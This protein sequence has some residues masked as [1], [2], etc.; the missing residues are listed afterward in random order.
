MT[1]SRETAKN[2]SDEIIYEA[3][4]V[5]TYFPVRHGLL[6]RVTGHVR[7]VD[8]VSISVE[9]GETVGIVGESGC[10]K[11]TFGRTL[12]RLIE[13]TEGSLRFFYNGELRDFLS[14]TDEEL[15][16]S[17]REMQ[18][19]FQDPYS[20]LNPRMTVKDII[21]EPL[22]VQGLARK[23]DVQEKVLEMLE[24]VS[25]RR[26]HMERFPHAFSGGQ[27]Q[28][29]AIARAMV[30]GPR[31]LVAD[32]PVSALDVSVQAQI[33]NLLMD[34]QT[35]FNLTMLFIAHD[36][37][38]VRH[39]SDRIAVM[40]LGKIVEIGNA[41]TICTQP[42]HP[43]TEALL[44]SVPL[45]VPGG[46]EQKPTKAEKLPDPANPP[47]GCY[48]HER[49]RY[50]ADVCAAQPPELVSRDSEQGHLS[51]CHFAGELELKGLVIDTGA[52]AVIEKRKSNLLGRFS[53][54]RGEV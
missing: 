36:I 5:K 28:R 20:S 9:S 29:I 1:D 35:E 47:E 31:F 14:L 37:D 52:P 54:V 32:E 30:L 39:V 22:R 10:G 13:P 15:R 43:Y 38:L 24:L 2:N 16:M 53:G 3:Q 46:R 26:E 50:A 41:Q 12:T 44:E 23:K 42:T 4:Q 17:R 6:R 21:G 19:I 33:L 34:L 48:F 25:L 11:T 8:D 40:Y 18:M 51:R 27:R 45:P 7:A 49:C